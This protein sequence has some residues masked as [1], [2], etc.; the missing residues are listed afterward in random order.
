MPICNHCVRDYLKE[1][2]FS[3]EIAD[4][5]CQALDIPWI[6]NE[7]QRLREISGDDVMESYV[8][9]FDNEQYESLDWVYYFNLYKKLEEENELKKELPL[10]SQE[11]EMALKQKWGYHY[12][13]EQLTYLEQLYEGIRRTQNLSGALQVDQAIKICK[14]SE[15][16]DSRIRAGEDFDKLQRT[17]ESLLKSAD[18][19][20]KNVRDA[21]DFES[22]G[23][24]IHW[25]EKRGFV[26]P[27]YDGVTRDIVD[28]T[29]KNIQSWNR[30]L[31][32]N[33]SGIGDQ[34]EARLAQLKVADSIDEIYGVEVEFDDDDLLQEGFEELEEFK[35]EFRV[36]EDGY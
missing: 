12:N 23:E 10:L 14:I 30:R 22:V 33:E 4:K 21:G 36:D 5:L 27:V 19:T 15:I 2:N 8:K 13:M 35:E 9:V 1:H 32:T 34:I 3:W 25:L 17:Y 7:F 26:N 18:F 16:I 31:Y 24:L 6:P 20:P 28:E 29:I 11:E